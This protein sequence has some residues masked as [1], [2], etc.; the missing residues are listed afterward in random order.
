MSEGNQKR[1]D[2]FKVKGTVFIKYGRM[3]KPHKRLVKFSQDDTLIEWRDPDRPTERPRHIKVEDI[4]R[5]TIGADHTK[6]MQRY[7]IPNEYDNLC[8][9]V[10]TSS[11][12]LDLRYDDSKLVSLWVERIK[13]SVIVAQ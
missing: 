12:S 9:S 8:F 4:I 10:I 1:E 7:N 6:V 3:G 2:K 5:V 13:L 11:R